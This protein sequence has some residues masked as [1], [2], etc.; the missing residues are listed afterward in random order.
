MSALAH[1]TSCNCCQAKG[2]QLLAGTPRWKDHCV[3]VLTNILLFIFLCL[4]TASWAHAI[5]HLVANLACLVACWE[6]FSRQREPGERTFEVFSQ[7]RSLA[8]SVEHCQSRQRV[9]EQP[10]GVRMHVSHQ[11]LAERPGA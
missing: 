6:I 5:G 11:L 7:F 8:H 1:T 3:T 9:P 10:F 4:E 2:V